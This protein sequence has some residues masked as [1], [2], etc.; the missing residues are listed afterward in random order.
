MRCRSPLSVR[1]RCWCGSIPAPSTIWI[2]TFAR[3]CRASRSRSR[4]YW[5]WTIIGSTSATQEEIRI[6]LDLVAREL[7]RPPIYRAFPLHEA[8]EAHR[9]LAGRQHYGKVVLH[10]VA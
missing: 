7:L 5:E 10:P 4:T 6:V 3:A 1:T 9:T 8:A 2:S